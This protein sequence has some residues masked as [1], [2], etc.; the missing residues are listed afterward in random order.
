MR[1]ARLT[2]SLSFSIESENRAKESAISEGESFAPTLL[3]WIKEASS[4]LAGP[5]RNSDSWPLKPLHREPSWEAV[6]HSE[7]GITTLLFHFSCC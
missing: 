6:G 3:L 4:E 7:H 2:E 1:R 5:R